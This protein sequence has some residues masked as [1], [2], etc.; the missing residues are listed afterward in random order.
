MTEEL[1]RPERFT[2]FAQARERRK[3]V[4]AAKGCLVCKHRAWTFAGHGFCKITSQTFPRC[5]ESGATVSFTP[6][7]VALRRRQAA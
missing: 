4:K 3:A 5:I 6:D 1:T 7:Y 2:E